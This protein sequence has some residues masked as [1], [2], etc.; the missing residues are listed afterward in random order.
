MVS[1]NSEDSSS[2]DQDYDFEPDHS[3]AKCVK[4]DM[5][6]RFDP[7]AKTKK[8]A[9]QLNEGQNE[10]V[11]KYFSKWLGETVIQDYILEECPIP[12]HS[13]LKPAKLD[14]D[15]IELLPMV[16]RTPTRQIDSGFHRA[17][18]KLSQV[19]APLCKLWSQLE[20]ISD[21]G[22]GKCK[23]EELIGLVEQ[24]VLL[25]GQ[26][27]SQSLVAFYARPEKSERA[28]ETQ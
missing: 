2:S 13:L 4:L 12:D 17:Q 26:L 19:M 11:T 21:R 6:G 3:V 8:F 23:V 5:T 15:M 18:S 16:A 10:F 27:P 7:L 1:S 14:S 22:T 25:T 24:S 28:T 9:W 20:D